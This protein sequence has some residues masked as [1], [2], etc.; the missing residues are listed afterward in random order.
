MGRPQRQAPESLNR[1][2]GE[3]TA[4]EVRLIGA[5]GDQLGI[6][7]TRDAIRMAEEQEMDLVEIAAQS[8]PPVC[9]LMNYGKFLFEQKK[10]K[11]EAK[12]NQKQI[13]V[14]EIKFRPGTEEGD[15]QVKF[16]KIV[17]FLG[18]GDKVKVIIWFRGR[19]VTHRELG[20][21]ILDRVKVD[22][23]PVLENGFVVEQE[24][25]LEGRQMMMV[26]APGRKK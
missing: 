26:L 23:E 17:E 12:K 14:K 5:E 16:K 13:Q 7:D 9:K 21:Q 25:K 8:E 20:V 4:R 19:E 2:N 11:A 22:L 1:L 24:A 18:E 15:Y 10:K 3:I 6:V